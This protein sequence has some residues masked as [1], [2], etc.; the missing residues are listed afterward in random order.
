MQRPP[1]PQGT[2]RRTS[3]RERT[4]VQSYQPGTA[5]HTLPEPPPRTRK[6]AA[7]SGPPVA[8]TFL[9]EE[10]YNQ[11]N[12]SRVVP[13]K[14]YVRRHQDDA[15]IQSSTPP[16]SS[17]EMVIVLKQREI[18]NLNVQLKDLQDSSGSD[19]I[20]EQKAMLI[21]SIELRLRELNIDVLMYN[22]DSSIFETRKQLREESYVATPERYPNMT[23]EELKEK[24]AEI[25]KT[26]EEYLAY[27]IHVRAQEHMWFGR[28]MPDESA[29]NPVY[30]WAS[31]LTTRTAVSGFVDLTNDDSSPPALSYDQAKSEVAE[32]RSREFASAATVSEALDD[33]QHN[34]KKKMLS[35]DSQSAK[36]KST[37]QR[38]TS[39]SS[40]L[41]QAD[42]PTKKKKYVDPGKKGFVSATIESES[43]SDYDSDDYLDDEDP[44]VIINDFNVTRIKQVTREGIEED[45]TPSQVASLILDKLAIFTGNFVFRRT[46]IKRLAANI[47]TI[48]LKNMQT[49]LNMPALLDGVC[50]FSYAEDQSLVRHRAKQI[51][52]QRELIE[53]ILVHLRTEKNSEA[54]VFAELKDLNADVYRNQDPFVIYDAFRLEFSNMQTARYQI[55]TNKK[56]LDRNMAEVQERSTSSA[57][58]TIEDV[59]KDPNFIP[60]YTQ[61]DVTEMLKAFYC[62]PIRV[63]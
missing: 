46:A 47:E 9:S 50:Q 10:E 48:G 36:K 7:G 37:Q 16:S 23:K 61:R 33:A 14:D 56:V 17:K 63:I 24:T 58:I 2:S 43:S 8:A 42:M 52:V 39:S 55:A 41:A 29:A 40:S 60:S 31:P 3:A 57:R 34:K 13:W 20:D 4:P 30:S 54:S 53:K 44:L 19:P 49:N 11:T 28:K 5:E 12:N 59:Y 25:K 45:M 26:L 27:A 1:P 38:P 6:N 35:Q 51:S 15:F 22:T 21:A 62:K 32:I 18:A